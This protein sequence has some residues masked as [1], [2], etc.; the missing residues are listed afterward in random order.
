MSVVLPR[1]P[2][3]TAVCVFIASVR[4][5]AK[6]AP[7][8]AP[9]PAVAAANGEVTPWICCWIAWIRVSTAEIPSKVIRD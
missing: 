5:E 3:S 8:V 1:P 6:S 2:E 4:S 9:D 7:V